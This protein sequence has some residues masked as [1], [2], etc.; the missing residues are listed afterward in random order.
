MDLITANLTLPIY[1]VGS[2]LAHLLD[3]AK[4]P[5]EALFAYAETLRDA[6][7]KLEKIAAR[8]ARVETVEIT[9]DTHMVLVE[10]PEDVLSPL[11]EEGLLDEPDDDE[12][13][14]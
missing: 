9:A 1:K 13:D 2:D 5:A 12:E 6:A 10:G 4:T 14:F 3:E 8:L 7:A 11:I